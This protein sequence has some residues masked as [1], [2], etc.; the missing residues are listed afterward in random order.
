M[1]SFQAVQ[2]HSMTFSP[3]DSQTSGDKNTWDDW[4]IVPTSRPVFAMP[5][6]KTQYI[7]IPGG[8]GILDL[9]NALTGRPRYGNR[10][11][12]FE[13]IVINE[14][15]DWASRYSN[16]STYLHGRS[17]KVYL[18]DDPLFYYEGRFSVNEW[19]SNAHYSL[20][21]IDYDVGP[22]KSSSLTTGERWLWDPF[23][24]VGTDT[25]RGDTIYTYKN[26]T[27]NNSSISID[28]IADVYET[29]P[30]FVCKKMNSGTAFNMTVAYGS[31][32]YTLKTGTNQFDSIVMHEGTNTFVFSGTGIVTI[33]NT[34]GRL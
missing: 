4:H 16:I 6:V 9:T 1:S 32:T 5:A 26:I 3:T 7:D 13:F 18:D 23:R 24:F 30:L 28:Y 27:L 11:G 33:E 22:Y 8:D 2:Y 14:Y 12:S 10:R 25:G 15:G 19:K 29:T 20:I 17:F 34:G 21:T 31:K